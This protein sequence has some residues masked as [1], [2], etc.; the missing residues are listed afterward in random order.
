MANHR[1]CHG[2]AD[3]CT[4]ESERHCVSCVNE[5]WPCDASVWQRK[6]REKSADR[7]AAALE[8]IL[9]DHMVV[10]LMVHRDP[11]MWGE[12]VEALSEYEGYEQEPRAALQ[13]EY[14]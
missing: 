8:R 1:P 9:D 6:G 12:A 11:S 5:D 10:V 3:G 2:C 4:A 7:L 13:Y 14:P